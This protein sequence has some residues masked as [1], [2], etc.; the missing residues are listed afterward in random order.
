[1]QHHGLQDYVAQDE[2]ATVHDRSMTTTE[3]LK[4]VKLGNNAEV[5]V[6]P[7]KHSVK[8]DGTLSNISVAK[9]NKALSTFADATGEMESQLINATSNSDIISPVL[10]QRLAAV[11]CEMEAE[12]AALVLY[13]EN[14]RED[15]TVLVLKT[16]L[17]K[18]N[19][20]RNQFKVIAKM[21]KAMPQNPIPAEEVCDTVPAVL[22]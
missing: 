16:S 2:H 20:A 14:N 15:D 3:S 17:V 1:M 13:K 18:L 8:D 7:T 11:K 21:L 4:A 22:A 6:N 12:A 9:L 5:N 19:E 10:V